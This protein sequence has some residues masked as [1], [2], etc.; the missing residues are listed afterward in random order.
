M[1]FFK[2]TIQGLKHRGSEGEERDGAGKKGEGERDEIEGVNSL[3]F[4][5]TTFPN[6]HPPPEKIIPHLRIH[7]S[8]SRAKTPKKKVEDQIPR[9]KV[10][11][12]QQKTNAR[13]HINTQAR[14]A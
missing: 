6:P 9:N 3:L 12:T 7:T 13:Y 2:Y 1:G 8:L 10:S 4:T 11:T 14:P 5:E